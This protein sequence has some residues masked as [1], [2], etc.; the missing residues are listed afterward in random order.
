VRRILVPI[1]A[2][3][4]VA[5]GPATRDDGV[6]PTRDGGVPRDAGY[7]GTPTRNILVKRVLDG[8]TIIVSASQG[9]FTPDNRPLDDEKIRLLGI[10]APEVA[11]DGMPADCWADEAHGFLTSQVA[12]KLVTIE[13]DSTRCRPGSTQNCRGD[14][15]RLLAYVQINGMTVNEAILENGHARVLGG[16]RFRHRD[17]SLYD[18]IEDRARAASL[19]VWSCP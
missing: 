5:C 19:G 4:A 3:V 15:G 18:Q 6:D 10:D 13:Y 1:V 2:A 17:S 16:S 9:I 11:H 12:G 14:F 8:D 7:Q